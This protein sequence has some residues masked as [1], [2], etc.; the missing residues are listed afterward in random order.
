MKYFVPDY[1]NSFKCI[2]DRCRH[3]C[4]IGW[5]IDIDD[6]TLVKYDN[7]ADMGKA[8]SDKFD[9]GIRRDCDPA[10]FKTDEKGRCV[11]LNEKGLCEIIL[12]Y[13][14]IY[15]CE[16][17]SCHPRFF[18]YCNGNMEQGIGLCCEE[19]ARLILEGDT[20]PE[21]C[22]TGENDADSDFDEEQLLTLRSELFDI[23]SEDDTIENRCKRLM[24]KLRARLP[25]RSLTDWIKIYS[26]LE[27]LDDEWTDI[28]DR[29]S[30]RGV[31]DE[32]YSKAEK[33]DRA[34]TRLMHYFIYRHFVNL[35]L[36]Y[37]T[38]L[39]ISFCVLSYRIIRFAFA[40]TGGNYAKLCDI[41]RLYSAEIEYS[42]QNID[43]LINSIGG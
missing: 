40:L 24:D 32:E 34:F 37:G 43:I 27:R 4:C 28:L 23:L 6:A 42:D 25:K 1:F 21:L 7:L 18:N 14:E 36:E 35:S 2:A 9:T 38:D 19:A 11:F 29:I 5:E 39:A 12:N 26:G 16:I 31:S 13:G 41:A 17:C 10:C 8:L 3:N 15:L 30:K 20:L 22:C 33:Y